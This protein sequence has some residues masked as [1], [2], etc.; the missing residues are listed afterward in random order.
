MSVKILTVD[1]NKTI[2]VGVKKAFQAFDCEIIEG[3]NGAEGIAAAV[4]EKPDL[5]LLDITM[6]VMNGIEMLQEL[7]CKPALKDIPVIML[8]A[9]SSKEN[10]MRV[11]MTGVE[12]YIVKPFKGEELIQRIKKIV[13]LE[14][15]KA[16]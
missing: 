2:R 11:V 16:V 9:G 5:I 10:V 12:D 1:D 14:P 6:P 8:T 4:L 7:K 15:K 13:K 3:E